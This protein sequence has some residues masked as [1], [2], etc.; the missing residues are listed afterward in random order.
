MI[1]LLFKPF[2]TR[3]HDRRLL[4]WATQ[5]R[6]MSF[7]PITMSFALVFNGSVTPNRYL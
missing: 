4:G 2:R 5:G 3:P 1:A 7:F 6:I